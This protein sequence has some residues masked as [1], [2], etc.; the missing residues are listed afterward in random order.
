MSDEIPDIKDLLPQRVG[1][2]PSGIPPVSGDVKAQWIA[3][4]ADDDEGAYFYRVCMLEP[5]GRQCNKSCPWRVANWGTSPDFVYDHDVAGTPT[6]NTCRY[7][8]ENYAGYWDSLRTGSYDWANLC[9]VARRGTQRHHPWVS[10]G[11]SVT[12]DDGRR[13]RVNQTH[14]ACQCT[15]SIV[16]LQREL[17]RHVECGASALTP[18]GAA[19]I[20]SDML[21]RTVN[22]GDLAGLGVRELLERAHPLLLDPAIG[23]PQ[24]APVSE[25][26]ARDWAPTLETVDHRNGDRMPDTFP[27]KARPRPRPEP[28][29]DRKEG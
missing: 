7:T 26:E 2:A 22:E 15:G 8:D 20:A 28:K 29:P 9:H 5:R 19:R 10:P 3:E 6:G 25:R 17:L 18:A 27:E 16:L 21:G 13:V 4:G 1:S 14:V 24:L 11:P 23:A 12:L